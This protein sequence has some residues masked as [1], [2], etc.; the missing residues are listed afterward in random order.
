MYGRSP[1]EPSR[2]AAKLRQEYRNRGENLRG[3]G[4]AS[5][6]EL[7]HRAQMGRDPRENVSEEAF[8]DRLRN[9]N[10][11]YDRMQQ[12][13][14]NAQ[15]GS[16]G[17]A[18]N[19]A[20]RNARYTGTSRNHAQGQRQ[21]YGRTAGRMADSADRRIRQEQTPGEVQVKSRGLPVGYLVMLAVVTMMIMTILFSISQIYQTTNTIDDLEKEL[22]NLQ[23]MA[24]ELELAIEE[25]NDI[26][27]IE[28]I[29]TDQ[30]GMVGEDSVQ[31]KYIS[32]SD[33]ERIDIIGEEENAVS[34][35]TFG[36][37]LSSIAAA[38]AGFLE[39]LGS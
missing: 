24:A 26:R 28:Q 7:M 20:Y 3:I 37:M 9:R 35:G 39:N 5:T 12:N 38:F 11:T 17:S 25:K 22:T 15:T 16:Y 2:L 6:E 36:T 18:Q 4:A 29:A 14:P 34:E 1:E 31:R 30:L 8:S 19:R 21:S 33:G 27:V 32:L 13:T 10:Y 23:T